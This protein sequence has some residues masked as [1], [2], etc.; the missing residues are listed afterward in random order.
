MVY[1]TIGT[2]T[3]RDIKVL[4]ALEISEMMESGQLYV[5][6]DAQRARIPG[7]K[8]QDKLR[9]IQKSAASRG[10]YKGDVVAYLMPD[11]RYA[12]SRGQH[13]CL[14]AM[15]GAKNGVEGLSKEESE[16]LLIIVKFIDSTEEGAAREDFL[17]SAVVDKISKADRRRLTEYNIPVDTPARLIKPRSH[18]INMLTVK[19]K[20]HPVF[21]G[22]AEERIYEALSDMVTKRTE[23]NDSLTAPQYEADI[24]NFLDELKA[25]LPNI[26]DKTTCITTLGHG[27]RA[28]ATMYSRFHQGNS[29]A[30]MQPATYAEKIKVFSD[31]TSGGNRVFA[32]LVY[33][34]K[35][36]FTGEKSTAV[37]DELEKYL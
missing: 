11:G 15:E 25:G 29:S 6:P 27:L 33:P 30:V 24:V 14:A 2:E 8:G 17:D 31:R 12:I 18:F 36:R 23:T 16:K 21:E 9:G 5:D 26:F 32:R 3:I 35:T 22:S 7:K 1:K 10:R 37:P 28:I 34:P 19:L 20:D 13:N 4:T